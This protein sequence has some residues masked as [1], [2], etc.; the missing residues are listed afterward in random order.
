MEFAS[1]VKIVSLKWRLSP[2]AKSP[3][4]N[5]ASCSMRLCL[6]VICQ[7]NSG[8]KEQDLQLESIEVQRDGGVTG[9]Q[10]ELGRLKDGAGAN[11]KPICGG[12]NE[13]GAHWQQS[14]ATDRL[15]P[16]TSL[17]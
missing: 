9:K 7:F 13:V 16:A 3:R 12:A 4:D 11:V 15:Q 6:R 17:G 8:L 14:L 5:E 2:S 10:P 1:V